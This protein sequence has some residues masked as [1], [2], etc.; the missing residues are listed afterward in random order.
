M[1]TIKGTLGELRGFGDEHIDTLNKYNM[2]EKGSGMPKMKGTKMYFDIILPTLA[3]AMMFVLDTHRDFESRGGEVLFSA[4]D[5][6]SK[7]G[8]AVVRNSAGEL[9]MG[10]SVCNASDVF[11]PMLGEFLALG[12][13]FDA[14]YDSWDIDAG[15]EEEM[16]QVM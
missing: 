12:R 4:V 2:K 10:Y 7:T 13:A 3:D 15:C 11:H 5:L 1:L 9:F 6:E 14:A 8:S 16:L